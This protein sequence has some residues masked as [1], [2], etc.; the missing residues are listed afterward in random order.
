[1][2][3]A[4]LQALVVWKTRPRR[5]TLA[6]KRPAVALASRNESTT[7]KKSKIHANLYGIGGVGLRHA[8]EIHLAGN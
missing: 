4:L 7:L 8:L 3:V 1:M 2:I 6:S 5:C